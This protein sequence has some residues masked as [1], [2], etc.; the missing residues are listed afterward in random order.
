MPSSSKPKN[1]M[2]WPM[3]TQ[4]RKV[5]A[6]MPDAVPACALAAQLSWWSSAFASLRSGVCWQR[7]HM[8]RQGG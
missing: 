3:M 2:T 7:H 8:L 5:W 1:G 6:A 4:T